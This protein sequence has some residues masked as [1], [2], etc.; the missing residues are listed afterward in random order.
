MIVP[1]VFNCMLCSQT[2]DSI[3]VDSTNSGSWSRFVNH[4]CLPSLYT[5][6]CGVCV[7]VCVRVMPAALPVHQGVCV[8]VGGGEVRCLLP[9]TARCGAFMPAVLH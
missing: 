9:K 8:C 2:S 1:Y 6:V 7:C 5:K 4:S 3:M